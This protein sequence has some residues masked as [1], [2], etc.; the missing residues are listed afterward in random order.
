ML[1]VNHYRPLRCRGRKISV[2]GWWCPELLQRIRTTRLRLLILAI[3]RVLVTG[4]NG[5]LAAFIVQAFA[6]NEVIAHTRQLYREETK[7]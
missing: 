1:F 4:A 7:S 2:E 5:Q 6:D 3:D